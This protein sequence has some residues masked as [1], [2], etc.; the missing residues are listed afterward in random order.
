MSRRLTTGV[1]LCAI[2]RAFGCQN[3]PAD[4][5]LGGRNMLA[6]ARDAVFPSLVHVSVISVEYWGGQEERYQSTGSGT[7]I[8][9]EGLVLTNAHVTDGGVEFWCTLADKTR[10]KATLVGED[11]MTDLA[12]LQIE[13]AGIDGPMHYATFGNSDTLEVGDQVLAMGSPF[14]L[15]RT[16]TYGIVSNTDRVFTSGADDEFEP[17]F[18]SGNRSGLLTNW[19]QHDALINP[20]NSG[21]PLVN[22]KGEIIGVNTRG[23]SGAGFA[24]PSNL[25]KRVAEAIAEHGEVPRTTIEIDLLHLERT[26]HTR[27]VFVDSV[28]SDGAAAKA[29]LQAGDVIL[30]IDG[31]P[32]TVNYPEQIPAVMSQF[33]HGSPGQVMKLTV[34][35]NDE[36]TEVDVTLDR[37][38]PDTGDEVILR[39]WGLGVR[40]ITPFMAR[41][42]R[43]DSNK[44]VLVAGV[45]SG[46]PAD[47][48]EVS[49]SWGDI[50]HSVDN[51]PI[52]S[53]EDLLGVYEAFLMQDKDDERP[54]SMLFEFD[55]NGK[56]YITMLDTEEKPTPNPPRELPKAWVG[57]ATQP[58]VPELAQ[59]MGLSEPGGF[60]ITRVYPKS[61]A[62]SS[63]LKAGDVIIAVNDED[64]KPR[65]AEQAGL[66]IRAIRE[67]SIGDQ[68]NIRVLRDGQTLDIPVELERS[69]T[70]P[71]EAR[72]VSNSDFGLSVRAVTFFDR[73]DY[74]WNDDI[75][76]VIVV[77]TDSAGWAEVAGITSGSLIR[78]ING[79]AID[80]T[81]DFESVMEEIDNEQPERVVFEVLQGYESSFKFVEP[82][83]K[84]R[85]LEDEA[86]Q[87][88]A[89]G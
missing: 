18:L 86:E 53:L 67:L 22:M 57:V 73:D 70:T 3:G 58:V 31:R 25:A 59:K 72:R 38:L 10:V 55:R 83:W 45:R 60:R 87:D 62:G 32:V 7:I 47:L 9:P 28:T 35:R 43:L 26:G 89:N 6:G 50:I 66:F 2:I 51:T 46:S 8:S 20:G 17:M 84:P 12:L 42:R 81:R 21:G 24:T 4:P 74:R 80:G 39:E 29:G 30:A 85:Q 52:E 19:I 44:G 33:A 36:E 63:D 37:Q 48:A 16:V 49:I 1:L 34:L 61:T 64:V 54:E 78:K 56:S 23:G 40:E 76:G 11:P 71:D 88:D 14:A 13:T 77:S 75:K 68:A 82:T 5:G 65:V 27:G 41:T 15:D 69:R 79:K